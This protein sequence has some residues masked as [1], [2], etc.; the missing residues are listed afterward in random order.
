V[1]VL[2]L[3]FLLVTQVNAQ[4]KVNECLTELPKYSQYVKIRKILNRIYFF[5]ECYYADGKN[6]SR[7]ARPIL[8]LSEKQFEEK[9]PRRKLITCPLNAPSES[10]EDVV[11][12][13]LKG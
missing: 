3:L 1:K 6:F 5:Q 4:Y 2:T 7:C 8:E 13:I 10:D 11:D 9:F 12:K